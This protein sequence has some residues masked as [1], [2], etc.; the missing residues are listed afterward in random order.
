MVQL[1][2]MVLLPHFLGCKPCNTIHDPH[3]VQRYHHVL[4]EYEKSL[5]RESSEE[6]LPV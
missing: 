5:T 1:C 2:L 6:L 4:Y 3:C